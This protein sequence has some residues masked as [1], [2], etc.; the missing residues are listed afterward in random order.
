M[1]SLPV[2]QPL[3]ASTEADSLPVALPTAIPVATTAAASLPVALPIAMPV[4][5]ATRQD[6]PV[7]VPSPAVFGLAPP[8]SVSAVPEPLNEDSFDQATAD[9]IRMSL[10]MAEA[11][12]R[13]ARMRWNKIKRVVAMVAR[14]RRIDECPLCCAEDVSSWRPSTCVHELCVD[15]A[16]RYVREAL[17]DAGAHVRAEGVRCAFHGSGCEN[18][19]TAEDAA[20]LLPL[21]GIRTGEETCLQP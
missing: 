6:L 4:A 11:P 9:A 14:E 1:S 3:D 21:S 19:L 2:A 8:L 12:R 20:R 17:Q 7:A 13:A 16:T 5:T 15:C 10:E 18:F